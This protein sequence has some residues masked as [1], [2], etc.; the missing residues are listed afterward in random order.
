MMSNR[1]R[2]EQQKREAQ[3]TKQTDAWM[4]ETQ[5]SGSRMC[6]IDTDSLAVHMNIEINLI[7]N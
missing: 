3:A 7:S 6:W 5:K 1:E 4:T 2:N